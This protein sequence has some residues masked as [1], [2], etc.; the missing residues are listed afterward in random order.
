MV[1]ETTTKELGFILLRDPGAQ[2]GDTVNLPSENPEVVKG[3][4]RLLDRAAHEV[5]PGYNR[6]AALQLRGGR[7]VG[8]GRE[9]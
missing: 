9:G 4:D 8:Q 6:A 7:P 3:L 5:H 1:H 2:L